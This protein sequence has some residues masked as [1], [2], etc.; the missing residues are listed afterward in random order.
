MSRSL[1]ILNCPWGRQT[2][3]K[4]TLVSNMG[5]VLLEYQPIKYDS[6]S[7]LPEPVTTPAKPDDIGTVEEL[8][9]TGLRIKQFHNARLNPNDYFQEA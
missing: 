9:F 6:P 7:E 3:L 5:E 4:A 2:D 1:S 8:Y